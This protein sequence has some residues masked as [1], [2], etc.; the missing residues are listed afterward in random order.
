[1]RTKGG[2]KRD[3]QGLAASIFPGSS[4]SPGF[5]G[6]VN[7]PGG[8]WS[9][10]APPSVF[11]DNSGENCY[12]RRRVQVSQPIEIIIERLGASRPE[13][14]T[15]GIIWRRKNLLDLSII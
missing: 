11:R 10:F 6:A 7:F 3:V 15:A 8:S 9:A 2:A 4:L 1:M 12:F 5:S 13:I 14:P